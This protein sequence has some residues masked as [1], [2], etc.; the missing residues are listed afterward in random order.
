[1]GYLMRGVL[2]FLF[3][4]TNTKENEPAIVLLK[5]SLFT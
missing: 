5:I 1:M 2:T 3:L 4:E